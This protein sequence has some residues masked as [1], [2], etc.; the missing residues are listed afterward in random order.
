MATV[1]WYPVIMYLLLEIFY[2]MGS[3][4]IYGGL[5]GWFKGGSRTTLGIFQFQDLRIRGLLV[6]SWRVLYVLQ[7]CSIISTG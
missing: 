4:V 1:Y 6:V 2:R 3:M 5:G 7:S